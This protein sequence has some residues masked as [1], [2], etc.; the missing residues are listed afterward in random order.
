MCNGG[1]TM[2]NAIWLMF[3]KDGTLIQF[4]QSWV[5]IGVQLVEDVCAHFHIKDIHRV[6]KD[7]GIEKDA[8][9]PGSIM[10]SGTLEEM[11]TVFNQYTDQ[12]TTS[13]TTQRSQAL[14]HAREPEVILFEGVVSMLHTLKSQ[15]YHL[16]ILTSDNRTGMAHFFEKTQLQ[17]LFDIVISTNG[18]HYEKPDP[19]ILEPLWER[20][21]KGRD[22]I[23]IGDTDNDMKTGRNAHALFN[24]GVRTGLGNQAT[25]ADADIILNEVTELPSLL[26]TT[27]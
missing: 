14:I 20:G 26:K 13:Y 8:F 27:H 23:M 15:G 6:K 9:T 19:R 11:V 3:D 10:A 16:G 22:M 5:K 24:V 12:D 17:S 7:V 4:D 18:D 25:F 1:D 21:V 2:P